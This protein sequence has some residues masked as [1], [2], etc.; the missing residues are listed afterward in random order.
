VV[1]EL[2]LGDMRNMYPK[3]PAPTSTTTTTAM[4]AVVATPFPAIGGRPAD[5]K[6]KRI[7]S[8]VYIRSASTSS[9]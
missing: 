6:F 4:T 8:S 5:E 1:L 9:S 7:G 2:W 3:I